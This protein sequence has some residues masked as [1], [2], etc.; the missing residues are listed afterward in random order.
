MPPTDLSQLLSG[1]T[2]RVEWKESHRN[3]NVVLRSVCA[4]AN[5]LGGSND[6]GYLV[7]GIKD[8][9]K[10][11]GLPPTTLD[12][13]QQLISNWLRSTKIYPHPAF[14]IEVGDVNGLKLLL[15]RVD[16]YPVPPVITV[17]GV[18][19][20]RKGSTTVRATEADQARLRE[21]RPENLKPFD[22]RLVAEASIADLATG[23][24]REEYETE[25]NDDGDPDTFPS[26]TK[27]LTSR[28]LGTDRGGR[29]RPN[30]AAML[31]HGIS[32]QDVIPGAFLEL[33]RYGG[34][35]V[36]AVIVNRKTVSGT[37]IAQLEAAWLWLEGNLVDEPA[38]ERGMVSAFSAEYPLDALKELVRNLL[39]HRQYEGT[40]APARIEWYS[41]RIELTNP[42]SP[43]GR[44]SEGELGEHS[45]YRN[46]LL[47]GLLV[48]LG[49]VERLGRGI[50]RVRKLLRDAG[51]PP[52]EVV[53]NGFT[54]VI[55][56]RRS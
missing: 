26:F 4:L 22:T 54:R 48:R 17:D 41:D 37:I 24:L 55:V 51:L 20:V 34:V 44:A 40:N 47:T 18:C 46:P 38:G 39:Q 13:E 31:V 5:D 16:P 15:V 1:E 33:V 7:I 36:D 56:R 19:W 35:D 10:V 50:R 45:D 49:Y 8:D 53:T 32:P 27:W 6:A 25:R 29:W 52:L 12:D 3:N 21:R 43:F 9:G 2:E 23:N 11:L 28:Q 14:S 30:A 42:G